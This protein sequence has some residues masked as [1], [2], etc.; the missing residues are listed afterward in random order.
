[1]FVGSLLESFARAGC[2]FVERGYVLAAGV[3]LRL[4]KLATAFRS[5]VQLV[6]IDL[7]SDPHRHR[8]DQVRQVSESHRLLVW[9]PVTLTFWNLF[10]R[11]ARTVNFAVQ[12]C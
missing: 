7:H 4:F 3:Q 6:L 12:F 5:N 1:M 2:S 8:R 9:F 10:E 11:V